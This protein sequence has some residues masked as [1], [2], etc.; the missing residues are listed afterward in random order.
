MMT[1]NVYSFE[2]IDKACIYLEVNEIA[3]E[4]NLSYTK[5][6]KRFS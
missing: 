5:Q 1:N 4:I 6:S 3:F 2:E